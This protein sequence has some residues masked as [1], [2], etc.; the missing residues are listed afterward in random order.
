MIGPLLEGVTV[1]EDSIS[2]GKGKL[3]RRVKKVAM[4]WSPPV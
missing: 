2:K 1:I 4:T 3:P